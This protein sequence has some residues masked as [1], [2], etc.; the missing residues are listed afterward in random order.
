MVCIWNSISAPWAYG[1][2]SI[3]DAK[4][5][6]C[7]HQTNIIT[8]QSCLVN[9]TLLSLFFSSWSVRMPIVFIVLVLGK[10]L[11]ESRAEIVTKEVT[12]WGFCQELGDQA[13]KQTLYLFIAKHQSLALITRVT[14]CHSRI[15]RWTPRLN[16]ISSNCT[17]SN[18]SN[19]SNKRVY[20]L[21][22][23]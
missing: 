4:H 20:Y 22:S 5:M 2:R 8:D 11:S 15:L 16:F 7:W 12:I 19:E 6:V 10:L 18:K 9:R 21:W 14:R 17:W 3:N 13:D 23:H 1:F